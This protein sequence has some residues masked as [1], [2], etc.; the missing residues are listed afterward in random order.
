M[1]RRAEELGINPASL[2][3]HAIDRSG[4]EAALNQLIQEGLS[5][6]MRHVAD[7]VDSLGAKME[8][9]E[10]S[11]RARPLQVALRQPIP[12]SYQCGTCEQEK[13]Q[14]EN[15]L[16]VMT[17]VCAASL[18]FPFMVELCAAASATYL[19]FY[20]AYAVCSAIVAFCEAYNH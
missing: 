11:G 12:D 2:P 7:F 20:S 10:R 15:A 16:Q 3:P 18:I 14:V 19:V 5:P 13:A 8:R 9:V 17:V 4:R 6:L 1:V